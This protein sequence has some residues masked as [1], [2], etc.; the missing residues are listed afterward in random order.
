MIGKGQVFVRAK[1]K[2]GKFGNVD[3]LDLDDESFR[4]VV[5]SIFANNGQIVYLTMNTEQAPLTQKK[6]S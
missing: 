6:G 1:T 4:R 3:V 2:E 5:M